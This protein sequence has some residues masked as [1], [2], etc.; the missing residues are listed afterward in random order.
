MVLAEGLA[1]TT[2]SDQKQLG[3]TAEFGFHGTETRFNSEY[4]TLS[5]ISS[6]Y[7]LVESE[8]ELGI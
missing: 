1:S 8:E 4:C 3:S 2:R 5:S 6:T 7:S